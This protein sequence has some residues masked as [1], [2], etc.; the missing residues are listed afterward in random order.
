MSGLTAFLRLSESAPAIDRDELRRVRD[1]M[2]MRGPD[3]SGEWWHPT[4][5]VAMGH[6]EFALGG[7][8]PRA[9]QPLASAETGSALAFDGRLYETAALGAQ[10]TGRTGRRLVT[11][12]D[13]ELLLRLLEE[14]GERALHDLRGMF[15]LTFWDERR[16]ALLIARDPFGI[17]PLYYASHGG[18]LRVASSVKAL[19]AGGA[20][21]LDRDPAGEAGFLLFGSVPEPYTIRRAISALPAGAFLWIDERGVHEPRAWVR[22]DH[23]LR[24]AEAALASAAERGDPAPG[25]METRCEVAAAVAESVRVHLGGAD[26]SVGCL[27]STS[28][29][30]AALLAIASGLDPARPLRSVTLAHGDDGADIERTTELAKRSGADHRVAQLTESD[31][32]AELPRLLLHMDQPSVDGATTYFVTKAAKERG[33][34]AALCGLGGDELFGA[35]FA[36]DPLLASSGTRDAQGEATGPLARRRTELARVQ[37]DRTAT[38]GAVTDV[39]AD[40]L[41]RRGLFQPEELP[42]L[43][44]LERA[45]A[46]LAALEPLAHVAARLGHGL[47]NDWSRVMALEASLYLRNQLLR[48]TDWASMAHA[49]EVRLPLVD[50]VLWRRVAPFLVAAPSGPE[51]HT[52]LRPAAEHGFDR[53]FDHSFDRGFD[54]APRPATGAAALAGWMER[55][56]DLDG[57]RRHEGLLSPGTS[58]ARRFACALLEREVA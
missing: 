7:V 15:A 52:A 2:S 17:K 30:S 10:L 24:A 18:L 12:T 42:G 20:L 29:D 36:H 51:G 22:L 53:G 38:H 47:A 28:A 46:G 27:V 35:Q 14:K 48:D 31:F 54:R 13:A 44:G 1:R 21:P 11:N 56:R 45:R 50:I 58:W 26:A 4:R 34:H 9:A 25:P 37:I 33:L 6:R 40:W 5:R 16:G 19:E 23:E 57:W 49:F 8:D 41:R 3:G 55:E 43:M 32:R 39:P